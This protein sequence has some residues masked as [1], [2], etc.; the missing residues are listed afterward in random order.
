M[1]MGV[2][3]PIVSSGSCTYTIKS[4]ASQLVI[5]V[6]RLENRGDELQHLQLSH[7]TPSS[8][9]SQSVTSFSCAYI[10]TVTAPTSITTQRLVTVTT[11]TSAPPS[12]GSGKWKYGDRDIE[13]SGS[14]AGEDGGGARDTEGGAG[15]G[16][17]NV[18]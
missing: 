6:D 16:D 3:Y 1:R 14:G 12:S 2:S 17:N 4:G 13:S 7:Y 15:S 11:P 5:E 9:F 10:H 8:L 18:D